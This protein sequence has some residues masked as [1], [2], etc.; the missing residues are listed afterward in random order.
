MGF[1]GDLFKH[2]LLLVKS[3]SKLFVIYFLTS[4]KIQAT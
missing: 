4:E 1:L 3:H 2:F